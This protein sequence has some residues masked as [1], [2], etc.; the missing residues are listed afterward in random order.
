VGVKVGV[1]IFVLGKSI[2]I[3]KNNKFQLNFIF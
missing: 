3:D 2:N 1:A